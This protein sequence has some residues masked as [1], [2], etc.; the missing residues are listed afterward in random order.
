MAVTKIHRNSRIALYV[1]MFISIIV[2]ALFVFGGQ[3]S[4]DE[5]IVADKSQPVFTDILMYWMYILLL[6]TVLAWLLLGIAGFF[7]KL[8]ESPKKALGSLLMPLALAVLLLVTYVMGS[9]EI[10]NISGYSGTDN[11]PG[12]LKVTDMWLYSAYA[13]LAITILSIIILPVFKRRK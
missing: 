7:R 10:L 6:V 1:S 12:T 11:N 8:K 5:K 13:M 2:L 4:A 9:G 3:V